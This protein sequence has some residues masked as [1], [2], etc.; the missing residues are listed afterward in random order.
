[1][2]IE[3]FKYHKLNIFGENYILAVNAED[4]WYTKPTLQVLAFFQDTSITW[5]SL[6]DLTFLFESVLDL[7]K[8][9]E[10]AK[11]IPTRLKYPEKTC[12]L[13]FVHQFIFHQI[14]GPKH[15][16]LNVVNRKYDRKYFWSWIFLSK[17]FLSEILD[18][19]N[20]QFCISFFYNLP[21]MSSAPTAKI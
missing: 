8:K 4:I 20:G 16:Q 17:A 12:K 10:R 19:Q 7:V 3:V 2:D 15:D 18:P 11:E 14:R 6:L 21:Q 1:M 9:M 5:D 13:G